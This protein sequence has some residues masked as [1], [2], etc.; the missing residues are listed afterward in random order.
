MRLFNLNALLDALPFLLLGLST[1]VYITVMAVLLGV[2]LGLVVGLSRI[3]RVGPLRAVATAYVELIRGTP[4]LVQLYI[5][6]FGLVQF[7][8]QLEARPAAII[9]LGVNSGAY[10]AEIVRA[11]IASVGKKQ[12]EAAYAL[13]M[14]GYQTMRLVVLPQAVRIMIPPLGNEFVTLIKESSLASVIGTQELMK[15]AGFV[16]SRTYQTFSTYVGAAIIYFILT[17]ITS[18]LL[19]RVERA[20]SRGV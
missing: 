15:Q 3:S 7:G 14:T 6:Y 18:A 12:A 8:L 19:R 1:T 20:V 13:G 5:V 16:V 17:T 4:L 11:G 2:A 10:V 9:A